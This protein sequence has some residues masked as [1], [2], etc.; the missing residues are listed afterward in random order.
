MNDSGE[1]EYSVQA[2]SPNVL[3]YTLQRSNIVLV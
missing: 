2:D 3:K 1:A